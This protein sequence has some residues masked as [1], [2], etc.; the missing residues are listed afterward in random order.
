VR[1]SKIGWL[2]SVLGHKRTWRGQIMMSALSPKA[3]AA[4]GGR[5]TDDL[6]RLG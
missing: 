6:V 4:V 3:A 5:V 2:M 1:H